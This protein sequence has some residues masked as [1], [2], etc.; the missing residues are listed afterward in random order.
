MPL[1]ASRKTRA[2]LP[3]SAGC[4]VEAWSSML[5]SRP[6]ADTMLLMDGKVRCERLHCGSAIH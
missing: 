5:Y 1:K 2:N 6:F 4:S 3:G